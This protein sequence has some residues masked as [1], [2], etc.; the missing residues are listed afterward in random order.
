MPIQCIPCIHHDDLSP[1]PA[2]HPLPTPSPHFHTALQHAKAELPTTATSNITTKS[3]FTHTTPPHPVRRLYSPYTPLLP[4]PDHSPLTNDVL[5]LPA[6]NVFKERM[7]RERQ[8]PHNRRRRL[9]PTATT[10]PAMPDLVQVHRSS[11]S[12]SRRIGLLR[13]V[14][15]EW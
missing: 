1:L 13:D 4:P 7:F 5:F 10:V 3:S 9:R 14:L 2:N 12:R 11:T 6:A 15:R 8:I